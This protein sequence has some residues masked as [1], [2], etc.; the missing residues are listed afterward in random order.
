MKLLF[1]FVGILVLCGVVSAASDYCT[2]PENVTT[3]IDHQGDWWNITFIFNECTVCFENGG[4]YGDVDCVP[5]SDYYPHA[6]FVSNVTCG[7]IPF[8]VQFTDT[9]YGAGI[10]DY[11]WDFGDGNISTDEN[12]V[13]TYEF[14]GVFS[15]NHSVTNSYGVGWENKSTFM[16]SRPVGDSC[17]AIAVVSTGS[18]GYK[19]TPEVIPLKTELI[20]VPFLIVPFLSLLYIF[21]GKTDE[22]ETENA[23]WGDVIATGLGAVVSAMVVIWFMT[24]GITSIPVTLENTSYEIPSTMLLTD[25]MAIQENAARDI[26]ILGNGGSGMFVSSAISTADISSGTTIVIHTNDVVKQQY[27]DTGVAILYMLLTL[28]LGA[29][30]GWSLKFGIDQIREQDSEGDNPE[31]WS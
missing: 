30:F 11:Y 8:G 10:T 18:T 7:I 20:P 15:V 29:L 23:I 4:G 12:P 17:E 14:T 26:S 31:Y 27:Q 25:A 5:C 13:H 3:I 2:P 22:N 24:G 6:N 16:L 19:P 28:I 1:I 21:R 9:S